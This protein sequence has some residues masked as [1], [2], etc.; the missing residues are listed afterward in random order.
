VTTNLQNTASVAPI[1]L[2]I[3]FMRQ[4]KAFFIAPLIDQTAYQQW[5]KDNNL[6]SNARMYS[7]ML[8]TA[9]NRD[10]QDYIYALLGQTALKTDKEC[11]E[12]GS[13]IKLI[14]FLEKHPKFVEAINNQQFHPL[15]RKWNK[16]HLN[17][18]VISQEEGEN[19]VVNELGT[20]R[21]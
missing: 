1:K 2:A 14:K 4:N 3:N 6:V 8:Q 20:I 13:R 9:I 21:L 12:Y 7:Q 10:M 16:D 17:E 5:C 18:A 19:N 11:L 15:V